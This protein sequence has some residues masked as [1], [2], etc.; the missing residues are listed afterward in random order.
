MLRYIQGDR[1]P[2]RLPQVGMHRRLFEDVNR[3]EVYVR[4]RGSGHLAYDGANYTAMRDQQ[5]SPAIGC[6][7]HLLPQ[8]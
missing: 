8:R 2:R 3:P 5:H 1:A 7:R 4:L 6:G